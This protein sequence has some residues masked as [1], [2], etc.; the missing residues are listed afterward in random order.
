MWVVGNSTYKDR[1][2]FSNAADPE[3][4]GG[5]DYVNVNLGDN[6]NAIAVREQQDLLV[7]SI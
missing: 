5:S 7:D 4:W 3:T 6:S 1:L 2:Y